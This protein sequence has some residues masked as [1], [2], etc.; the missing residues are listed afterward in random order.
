LIAK[1]Y[2]GAIQLTDS[3]L[4]I[5]NQLYANYLL[6]YSYFRD[7]LQ[8]SEKNAQHDALIC[9]SEFS[10]ECFEH[11]ITVLL[12]VEKSGKRDALKPVQSR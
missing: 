12:D 2:Y 1:E 4:Q 5:A 9:I 3:G 11:L 7:L 10:D 8:L 6:I